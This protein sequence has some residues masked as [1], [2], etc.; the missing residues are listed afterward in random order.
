[1]YCIKM[2]LSLVFLLAG[3]YCW[4]GNDPLLDKIAQEPE[5]VFTVGTNGGVP[6]AFYNGKPVNLMIYSAMGASAR[7]LK[8]VPLIAAAGIHYYEVPLCFYEFLPEKGEPDFSG[9]P[10]GIRCLLDHDNQGYV[11]V[12]LYLAPP[13]WWFKQHPGQQIKFTADGKLG[14]ESAA[15]QAWRDET[16]KL[17]KK[18][19][20]YLEKSPYRKRILGYHLGWGVTGE[21]HYP[22]FGRLPDA[23][24]TM[25]ACFHRWLTAKYG[26]HPEFASLP[27]PGPAQRAQSENG[28][29]R[30]PA[31]VAE[32]N[33]S[34]YYR[35]QQE[36]VRDAMLSFCRT[37]RRAT[38]GKKLIG[39]FYGYYFHMGYSNTE[40]AEGGHL[41][42]KDVFSAPDID[43]LSGP[44]SYQHE[45]R[46]VGGDGC[47]RSPLESV[48]LHGKMFF[49]EADEPTYL[50]CSQGVNIKARGTDTVA[51]SISAMRR[52]F[53]NV[54]IHGTDLWW[55]D[56]GPK[57]A[58]G[59]FAGGWWDPP[60]LNAEMKRFK[61]IGVA[62]LRDDRSSIAQVAV[63]CNP[64]TYYY[65]VCW[66]SGKDLF[67]HPLLHKTVQAMYLAGAPFDLV[68]ASDLDR[69]DYSRYRLLV[70]LDDFYLNAAE[71]KVI[72]A[73]VKANG[74]T[75]LW[76]YAPGYVDG[77]RLS[78][79]AMSDLI[80][81]KVA[82]SLTV[83]AAQIKL[84]AG[85]PLGGIASFGLPVSVSPVFSVIDSGVRRLGNI[86][87]TSQCGFALKKFPAWTSIYT[88]AP[89][90]SPELLRGIYQLAGVHIYD[91]ENDVLYADRS[92]VAIT[93]DTGGS[94]TIRLPARADVT[95][96]FSGRK[97]ATDATSFRF[98]FAP[99]STRL[100]R[101]AP[102][103]G[104]AR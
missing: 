68:V 44:Y 9:L 56:I 37:A 89:P 72:D 42:M 53:C 97:L 27:V 85:T 51:G 69:L 10:G 59:G 46:R 2:F 55:F 67:T 96:L 73:K 40:Q 87:G 15:S 99:K 78:T 70:F 52:N 39:V 48:K 6:T 98:D 12:R 17:L 95:D 61:E 8:H 7:P 92:Y 65:I 63:V 77:V 21:W 43:F 64:E 18:Y 32:R 41:C 86:A 30:N 19:I 11:M 80:G 50:G 74:H 75:V 16:N 102:S 13:A 60:A 76:V 58:E 14:G 3:L 20:D 62:S 88:F 90:A 5:S 29:F 25:T 47:L 83:G 79:A 26:F 104:A 24:E 49:T 4:S 34:D 57:D 82:S 36:A 66:N 31:N 84:N 54:M 1:M 103:A 35:C 100:F 101:I 91:A 94:R 33:V 28:I 45:S 23:G 22:D 81:M 38:N 93:G 71:R